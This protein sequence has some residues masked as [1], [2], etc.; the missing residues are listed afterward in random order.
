MARIAIFASGSGTN[1]LTIIQ[2]FV[3]S[4][5]SI[6][7]IYCNKPTAEIVQTAPKY[8]VPVILFSRSEFY[9]TNMV[10]QQL[11]EDNIDIIVLAGFLWLIPPQII[12]AFPKRIINIH[13][14]LLPKYGGK[15][16]YGMNVHNA[17]IQNQE[18]QS[19]ITIHIVDEQYDKGNI[20]FQAHC[21]VEPSD[22][23]ES[24]SKKVQILEH[25]HFSR[26]IAEYLH[27][28]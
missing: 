5:H 26:V 10:L 8:N 16:M 21:T 9:E 25:E 15:G 13:P 27:M 4:T 20:V 7:S 11:Q 1:A 22:T 3:N 18:K 23:A 12:A 28:L 6:V 14:S 17:V 19:G 2:N 24:L